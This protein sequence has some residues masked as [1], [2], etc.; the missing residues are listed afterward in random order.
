MGLQD[1]KKEGLG[2]PLM[3]APLRVVLFLPED[4]HRPLRPL[5]CSSPFNF[6]ISKPRWLP[7]S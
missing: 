1:T 6:S 3:A 5:H 4:K 7:T 2:F